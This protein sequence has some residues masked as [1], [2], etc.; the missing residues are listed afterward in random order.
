LKEREQ[1]RGAIMARN[2]ATRQRRRSCLIK[3]NLGFEGKYEFDLTIEM[4]GRRITRKA[5]AVYEHTP[6]WEYFDLKKNALR[7]VDNSETAFYF[8]VLA[9]PQEFHEDGTVTDEEPYWARVTAIID[10]FDDLTD[11]LCV[12][13]DDQCWSEDEERRK[14]HKGR[15]R[16]QASTSRRRALRQ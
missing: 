2:V 15:R 10:L 1:G 8:E 14:K 3:M 7:V 13:I 6:C 12:A 5:R 11:A 4:L 16:K 9:M